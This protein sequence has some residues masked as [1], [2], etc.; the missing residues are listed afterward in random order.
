MANITLASACFNLF[1]MVPSCFDVRPYK[2]Q[3][4]P[5]EHSFW[6]I[7][8][9]RHVNIAGILIKTVILAQNRAQ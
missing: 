6:D 2:S 8:L 5:L 4:K 1:L 7:L 9:M 3:S